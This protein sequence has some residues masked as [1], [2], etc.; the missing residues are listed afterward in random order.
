MVGRLLAPDMLTG[1]GI[2]TLSAENPA[3]NPF[4]YQ[5]GS[6]WPHDNAIIAMGAKSYGFSEQVARIEQGISFAGSHTGLGY[7]EMTGY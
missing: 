6:V 4:S 3:Y 1:W 7:L 5:T 2:R